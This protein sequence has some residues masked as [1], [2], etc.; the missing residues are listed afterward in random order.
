MVCFGAPARLLDWGVK[1]A[2]SDKNR[3]ATRKIGR[4]VR[5]IKPAVVII[6]NRVH[7]SCRRSER[8]QMLLWDTQRAGS[9]QAART[10]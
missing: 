2:R 4:M 5:D 1:E 8:V 7:A 3:L 10:T 9:P 6:E